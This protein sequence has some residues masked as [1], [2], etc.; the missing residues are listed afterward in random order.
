MPSS[1]SRRAHTICTT[2]MYNTRD[3][4]MNF[5]PEERKHNMDN[6][7]LVLKYSFLLTVNLQTEQT[8]SVNRIR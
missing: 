5:S 7:S 4:N 3:T 8:A 6:K 1:C 2:C